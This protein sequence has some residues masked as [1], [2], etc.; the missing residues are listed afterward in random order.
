MGRPTV[1]VRIARALASVSWLASGETLGA[2]HICQGWVLVKLD[3]FGTWSVLR[4]LRVAGLAEELATREAFMHA[5]RLRPDM[6]TPAVYVA[7][8][9][10]GDA[11]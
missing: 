10:R 11:G 4:V 3:V 6:L 8:M 2:E 7:A 9:R 1:G 5:R